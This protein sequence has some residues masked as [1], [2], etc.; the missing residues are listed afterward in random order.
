[1]PLLPALRLTSPLRMVRRVLRRPSVIVAEVAAIAGA[2]TVMTLIPQVFEA[3]PLALRHFQADWPTLAALAH[4]LW[5]DRMTEAPWFLVLVGLALASLTL[6]LV[7][8]LRVLKRAWRRPPTEAAL[9][10][11][12]LQATFD[13]RA[14][15]QAGL[16]L[17]QTGRLGLGGSALLHFGLVSC[18]VAGFGGMLF[19][20]S[21]VFELVVGETLPA[22]QS[23]GFAKQWGGPLSDPLTVDHAFTLTK[24]TDQRYPTGESKALTANVAV[25]SRD[26]EVAVN[27]PVD[28]G[29]ERVYL[30]AIGGPA[31]LTEVG[32]GS[33]PPVAIMMRDASEEA[34][35]YSGELNG[36]ELHLRAS[37]SRTGALPAEVYVRVL[38]GG[39]LRYSGPLTVGQGVDLGQ[40]KRVVV[41]D[42]RHWAQ[43][44]ARRDD[45]LPLAWLGLSC[46]VLGALLIYGVSPVAWMI[47]VDPVGDR[48]LVVIRMKP[49]RFV[50]LFRER[51][52]ALVVAEGGEEQD[53]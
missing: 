18:V 1:M 34:V 31:V 12:P 42:I 16:T 28:I 50:P 10:G 19:A 27:T 37:R 8:Q 26:V 33:A 40:G 5:L 2:C 11:A 22:L 9:I 25:G 47:R 7:E 30:T 49:L 32:A 15:G 51:F 17:A 38:I 23:A 52:A 3:S 44:R 24:L 53:S 36:I 14:R 35:E 39:G 43:F 20:R 4:A 13:R 29:R 21:G 6:V 46:V 45:A 48:E 41:R